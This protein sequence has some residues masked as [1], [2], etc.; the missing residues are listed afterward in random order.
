MQ[1]LGKLSTQVLLLILTS[2]GPTQSG[3]G[4]CMSLE[5]TTG[6]NSSHIQANRAVALSTHISPST[7]SYWRWVLLLCLS[8][9]EPCTAMAWWGGPSAEH[10]CRAREGAV[11][12]RMP[13]PVCRQ[14]WC[15]TRQE[16]LPSPR[17]SFWRAQPSTEDPN[18]PK[19]SGR[20]R[21]GYTLQG[22]AW[23]AHRSPALGHTVLHLQGGVVMGSLK[24]RQPHHRHKKV[25]VS[26]F[27]KA[28][29]FWT[30]STSQKE[31]KGNMENATESWRS[32]HKV[33]AGTR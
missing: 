2:P 17:T 14:V 12:L 21:E 29:D 16:Q 25:K 26:R 24:A 7:S 1:R 9:R 6:I 32:S 3:C 15:C 33:M 20:A 5:V 10:P 18:V 19:C 11:P 27:K 13:L 23:T 8:W 4:P 22:Q 28:R 31:W 30:P